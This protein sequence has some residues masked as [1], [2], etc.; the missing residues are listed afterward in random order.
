VYTYRFADV[1]EGRAVQ[2]GSL[3]RRF[4]LAGGQVRPAAHRATEGL[5]PMLG[6]AR[7]GCS[8]AR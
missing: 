1:H 3:R 2:S 6:S 8:R 5:A 7:G 4:G